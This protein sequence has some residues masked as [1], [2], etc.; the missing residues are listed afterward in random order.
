MN[1][2]PLP[3][4][5]TLLP[6]SLSPLPINLTLPTINL[7]P[8]WQQKTRKSRWEDLGLP[9]LFPPVLMASTKFNCQYK[10]LPWISCKMGPNICHEIASIK[11]FN[12]FAKIHFQ[13]NWECAEY[14][15]IN[16]RLKADL[17][18]IAQQIHC[19]L[20]VYNRLLGL[21]RSIKGGNTDIR[22]LAKVGCLPLYGLLQF[23]W[24]LVLLKWFDFWVHVSW[25][26]VWLKCWPLVND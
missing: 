23:H 22:V 21:E 7:W 12:S 3:M 20:Q 26:V 15:P 5:L 2:T 19:S 1:L 13:P 8:R 18:K 11:C 6:I 25:H 9:P 24:L 16:K 4:N 14:F 17:A 10:V